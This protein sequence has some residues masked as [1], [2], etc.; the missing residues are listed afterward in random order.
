MRLRLLACALIAL[1]LSTGLAHA[2][3]EKTLLVTEDAPEILSQFE[4]GF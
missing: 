1:A 4:W 2:R 3:S